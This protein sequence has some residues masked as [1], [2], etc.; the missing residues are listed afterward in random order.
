[1]PQSQK[2]VAEQEAACPVQHGDIWRV[3]DHLFGCGDIEEGS[4]LA[5]LLRLA[6]PLTLVYADPP[7]TSA[8]ATSYRTM[9]GAERSR[10]ADWRA[11]FRRALAPA[12]TGGCC[13]TRRWAG[14]PAAR[15]CGSRGASAR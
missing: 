4:V 12:G 11:V 8:N 2:S 5:Q 13:A 10:K 1:M 7:W 6:R 3:G 14:S 9:S 15:P